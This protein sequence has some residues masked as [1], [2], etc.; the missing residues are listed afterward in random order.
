MCDWLVCLCQ[1]APASPLCGHWCTEG[2]LCP[3]KM[4]RR[5]SANPLLLLT[6][7]QIVLVLRVESVLTYAC[8]HHYTCYR[9]HIPS[10]KR[11]YRAW[12]SADLGSTV[13]HCM[14]LRIQSHIPWARTLSHLHT[15]LTQTLRAQYLARGTKMSEL[16]EFT[17]HVS[18]CSTKARSLVYNLHQTRIS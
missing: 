4:H 15:T 16:L 12:I 8:D 14:C 5:Q 6:V 3:N 11:T 7:L 13:S 1:P 17:S 2:V 9:N 18:V 10:V